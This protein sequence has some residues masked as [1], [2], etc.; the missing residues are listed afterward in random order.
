MLQHS[1]SVNADTVCPSGRPKGCVL[2][3]VGNFKIFWFSLK[4]CLLLQER[5]GVATGLTP[6]EAGRFPEVF[7]FNGISGLN[8]HVSTLSHW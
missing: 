8:S 5:Q 4:E 7:D 6:D 1:V 3:K 2:G